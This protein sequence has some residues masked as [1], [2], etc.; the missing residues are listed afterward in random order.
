MLNRTIAPPITDAVNFKLALKLY[1][2]YTL[3]NGVP[4]FV[5]NAGAEEVL[6][7]E[8][9]FYAGNFYEK[10]NGIAAATNFLLRNGTTTKTALEINEAFEFYGAFCNRNCFN[11]TANITLH[12]LSRHAEK[13]LP[14]VNDMLTNSVFPES[15][16]EIYKQNSI[17]KLAVNLQKCEFVAGRTI[18][19]CVY[20]ESHPYGKAIQAADIAAHTTG[21]LKSFYNEF[22]KNGHC[23]IFVA[24]K[25]P[26]GFIA[27]LNDQFGNL[28][29]KAASFTTD[30]VSATPS[31]EKKIRIHNDPD[32]VQGAIRLAS[33]FPNRHHPD[34]T[35]A[36]MLNNLF[37][38]FF[39][40]R[41][42]KNIREEKG[43]TY[44]IYSYLQ[45]HIQR[46]AWSISTEAGKE[47]C[48]PTIAE[49][50]KEMKELREKPV[51]KEELMLVKN[52]MMGSILGD[53]DGPFHILARWKNIILNNLTEQYFYN[54]ID[55]IRNTSPQQLQE[56]ANKYL[57]PEHFYEVVVY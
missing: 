51:E 55:A 38:G 8:W 22:Y 54:S 44:G 52:Y 15:E 39:G 25:L 16:L 47:V 1:E 9:L 27:M 41:L 19:A 13:L 33:P 17:Q 6:M 29:I 30:M 46:S 43:Y 18:D 23:A 32:A 35:K 57:H 34:F 12:T 4:V 56:L 14:V 26:Q 42:M 49:I 36:I 50:Y 5:I 3:K 48:E 31:A 10:E 45:N 2:K 7:I 40:S 24:G 20:G 28:P 11:E 53:L 37:G 21:Q